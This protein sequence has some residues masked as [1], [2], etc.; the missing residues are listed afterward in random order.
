[1]RPRARRRVTPWVRLDE[2][3]ID[4]DQLLA[5]DPARRS[6]GT[7]ACIA[8]S[9]AAVVAVLAAPGWL[10]PA[11]TGGPA[12]PLPPAPT[13]PA[14]TIGS[15]NWAAQQCPGKVSQ[16]RVPSLINLAGASFVHV[17]SHRQPV[18]QRDLASR[19]LVTSV[20]PASGRRWV[21]VGA[22][23]ASSASALSVQLGS[24][25]AAVVPPGTLTFLSLPQSRVRVPVTI[26]DYGRPGAHESLRI[27]EYDALG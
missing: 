9:V 3:A 7:L 23:G 16:C 19:T 4:V 26:A 20:A 14:E 22:T 25:D 1:V 21:L 18:L 5:G 11:G 17:R 2:E 24:G 13:P 6:I 8:A 12:K 27:E 10:I 15:R